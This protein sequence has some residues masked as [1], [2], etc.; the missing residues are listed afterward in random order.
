MTDQQFCMCGAQPGY[1]HDPDCPYPYFGHSESEQYRWMKAKE[2][3]QIERRTAES[4]E[5]SHG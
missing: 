4:A 2:A 1:P 3:K 5:V